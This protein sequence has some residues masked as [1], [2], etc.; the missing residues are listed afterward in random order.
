[1]VA[2]DDPLQQ[3]AVG[4]ERVD[5]TLSGC[6]IPLRRQAGGSIDVDRATDVLHVE[7][8][9]PRGKI[10]IDEGRPKTQRREAAVE[11]VDAAGRTVDG[12]QA[13]AGVIDCKA[14]VDRPRGARHHGRGRATR[15]TGDRAVQVSE[16]EAGGCGRLPRR[17]LERRCVRVVDLARRP[18]RPARRRRNGDETV[19][20]D[21]DLADIGAARHRVERGRVRALVGYPEGTRRA[22]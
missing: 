21:V 15:P 19:R 14:R 18:L 5:D 13:C 4:V 17:E 22:A 9:Q 2:G 10:G 3:G 8:H 11:D 12:I 6:G 16:D 20:G 1:M 7:R